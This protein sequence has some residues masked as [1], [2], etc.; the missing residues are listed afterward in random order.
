MTQDWYFESYERLCEAVVKQAVYDYQRALRR[1]ARHPHDEEALRG[2]EECERFFRRDM[3]LYSDLDG[4]VIIKAIRQRVDK[5][6][7]R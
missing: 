7:K 5:E 6:M 1:L 2:K 4:E 3:A